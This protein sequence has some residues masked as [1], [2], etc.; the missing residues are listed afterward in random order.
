MQSTVLSVKPPGQSTVLSVKPPGQS[1]AL[2][3]K[4]TAVSTNLENRFRFLTISSYTRRASQC[5]C[6]SSHSINALLGARK[7]AATTTA[8]GS[9][10]AEQWEDLPISDLPVDDEE[11]EGC[12]PIDL[13]DDA[14]VWEDV[15]SSEE[16]EDHTM[17]ASREAHEDHEEPEGPD[18]LKGHKQ[19][20][21]SIPVPP[22]QR[23]RLIACESCRLKG[24]PRRC[25]G[26]VPRVMARAEPALPTQRKEQ[27]TCLSCRKEWFTCTCN[28]WALPQAT[29]EPVFVCDNCR[30]KKKKCTHIP[31]APPPPPKL[32]ACDSCRIKGIARSCNGQV[33][34]VVKKTACDSCRKRRAACLMNI[35]QDNDRADN[36]IRLLYTKV[37]Q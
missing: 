10:D 35:D 13:E 21:G 32:K 7:V 33:P 17:D 31:G 26:R 8:I 9:D 4:P 14:D 15:V 22:T 1:T 11:G 3:I 24:I 29:K 6:S 2:S 12:L 20:D 18:A 25:N 28:G 36:L 19:N 23:V 37:L 27:A 34:R 5:Q 16:N 30:R